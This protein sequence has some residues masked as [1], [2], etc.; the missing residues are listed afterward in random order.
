[1]KAR[2]V[3][4]VL[5]VAGGLAVVACAA[6]KPPPREPS[7]IE[8]VTDAG[9]D[10]AEEAEAPKPKSLF[11]RLGNQEGITKVVDTFVKNVSAD[12]KFN[13]RMATIKGAKLDKF[14]KDFVDLLCVE[15]G[16]PENGADC[17]YE[18]RFM[19][20]VLGPKAK[21]KEEEWQALL[22]GLRNALEEHDIKSDEQQDLA[23]TLA[24]FRDDAVEPAKVKPGKK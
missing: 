5:F 11:E 22:V 18:G 7:H 14:K 21:F 23:S 19:K 17:K 24:K 8:V 16:G 15:S 9:P 3:A 12:T 1:M 2:T 10:A 13:K 6:K 20:E 4:F